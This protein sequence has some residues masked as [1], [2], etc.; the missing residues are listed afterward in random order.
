[1]SPA[2]AILLFGNFPFRCSPFPDGC[3]DGNES[4]SVALSWL[5]KRRFNDLTAALLV[6]RT[7]TGPR[8]PAARRGRNTNRS[9][10]CLLCTVIFICRIT[11][12]LFTPWWNQQPVQQN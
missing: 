12:Y 4:T 3:A 10:V 2:G 9:R 6:S 1:M 8:N 11:K 7:F 5:R